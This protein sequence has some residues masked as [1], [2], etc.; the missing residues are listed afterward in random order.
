MDSTT[1]YLEMFAAM[2]EGDFE[3]ARAHALNLKR[4]LDAGG[5]YPLNCK[6]LEVSGHLARVLRITTPGAPPEP[7]IFSLTCAD[8][9]FGEG[10]VSEAEAI[11]AGWTVSSRSR[12]WPRRTISASVPAVG[13]WP[14]RKSE[15]IDW[16]I[17]DRPERLAI[18]AVLASLK[19][20]SSALARRQD[21]FEKTIIL[22]CFC[23]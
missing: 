16:P 8:C 12:N 6:L 14:S 17:S 5:F 1:C 3:T 4:W 9:D 20:T 18:G 13:R 10:I 23:A 2:Q 7:E 22:T 21:S 11:E 19:R 15:P